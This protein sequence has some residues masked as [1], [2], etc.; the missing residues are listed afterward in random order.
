MLRLMGSAAT[1]IPQG[2]DCYGRPTGEAAFD[3][4]INPRY[5]VKQNAQ[6]MAGIGVLEI[7]GA[8]G[9]DGSEDGDLHVLLRG[10]FR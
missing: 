2:I 7:D 6:S 3:M 4:N 1:W 10:N 5:N 9:D 8:T